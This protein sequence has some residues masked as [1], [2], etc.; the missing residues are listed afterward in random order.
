MKKGKA[1]FDGKTADA[2]ADEKLLSKNNIK[3]PAVA[4]ISSML[5]CKLKTLEEFKKVVKINKQ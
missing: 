2:M 5:G 3:M 4:K 1:V